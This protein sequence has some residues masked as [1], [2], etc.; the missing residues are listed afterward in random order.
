MYAEECATRTGNGRA[1]ARTTAGVGTPTGVFRWYNSQ[2]SE[3]IHCL[4][5]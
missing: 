2:W 5:M 1:E 4:S 3:C